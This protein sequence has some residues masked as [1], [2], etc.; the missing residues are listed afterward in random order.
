MKAVEPK[1]WDNR[2]FRLGNQ[3]SIR[4]PSAERYAAKVSI[5]HKWLPKLF[6]NLSIP[7]PTPIAIGKPTKN[8]PWNWSIYGW[9]EG[10]SANVLNIDDEFLKMFDWIASFQI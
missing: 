4:L 5:E 8:Y 3:M 10:Q 6:S 1:G 2:T 9:I 7:I